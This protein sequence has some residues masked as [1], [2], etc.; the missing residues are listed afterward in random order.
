ML[1]VAAVN[2]VNATFLTPSLCEERVPLKKRK[3]YKEN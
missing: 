3:Q 1:L 2:P